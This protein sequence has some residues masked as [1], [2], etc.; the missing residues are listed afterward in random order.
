MGAL[1][2]RDGTNV[3][4]HHNL[5]AHNQDRNPR[6]SGIVG[7][8]VVNN[9]IYNWGGGPVKISDHENV[10]H[11]LN[12]YF[13]PG[14]DSADRDIQFTNGGIDPGTRI[15]VSGNYV[16]PILGETRNVDSNEARDTDSEN[17][18]I[19]RYAPGWS[20]AT[21]PGYRALVEQFDSPLSTVHSAQDAY[22]NVL[23][24][25]GATLPFH[26]SVDARIL[27]EV[28]SRTG[29]II[30]SQDERGGW[31]V[32]NAGTPLTDSDGDG[33]P[34]SWEASQGLNSAVDD[35]A[36]DVDGDGY[37]N[38][39]N[40]INGLFD[41]RPSENVAPVANADSASTEINT[42]V[43]ITHTHTVGVTR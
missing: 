15:H 26:D 20:D 4:F 19:V 17:D 8:E 37:T 12:N 30:D 43:T 35:S 27:S 32:Y 9:V 22:T 7:A 31:P 38:I 24:D 1:L 36:L 34:D 5:L 23:D 13:K 2:G 6:I 39:E 40:Y 29:S 41:A 25:V 16:D 33:M 3:S 42:A 21:P 14:V 10:V 28:V 11:V 18:V